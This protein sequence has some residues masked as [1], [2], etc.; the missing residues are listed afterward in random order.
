MTE[1][2]TRLTVNSVSEGP[3]VMIAEPILSKKQYI[4][5]MVNK[6]FPS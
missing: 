3:M 4:A 1:N 5:S 6:C 2:I